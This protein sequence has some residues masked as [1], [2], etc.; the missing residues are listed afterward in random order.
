[1]GTTEHPGTE[2][3]FTYRASSLGACTKSI[4]AARSGYEG[5]DVFSDMQVLEEGN[6][7]EVAVIERLRNDGWIISREQEEVY[8]ELTGFGVQVQGHSDG[9]I[10]WP[11]DDPCVLEVKSMGDAS[12]KDWK[13]RGWSNPGIIQKYK[14]QV[15]FYMICFAM[16]LHFVVKNRNSGEIDTD[17]VRTPFYSWSD[18]VARI[19]NIELAVRKGDLP[20]LCDWPMYPCPFNY[21]HEDEELPE[22]PDDELSALVLEYISKRDE[23]DKLVDE[24][25]TILGEIKDKA[26]G[27]KYSFPFASYSE[28][29]TRK[30][31]YDFDKMRENGIDVDAYEKVSFISVPSVRKKKVKEE[32]ATDTGS[33]SE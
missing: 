21:L 28:K 20:Q 3:N 32:D 8:K 2:F 15:S 5:L 14:W 12:F 23:R 9:I 10:Q 25:K 16:P 18:I 4:I 27:K 22:I 11:G 30:V 7:H 26:G 13:R 6:L 33:V 17:F 24:C 31:T 1:M 19:T 29:N